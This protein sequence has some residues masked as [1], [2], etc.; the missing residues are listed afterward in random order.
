[1]QLKFFK[2]KKIKLPVKE[3]PTIQQI[4]SQATSFRAFCDNSEV[5]DINRHKVI[6]KRKTLFQI[7]A[8]G[9][10]VD[11]PVFIISKN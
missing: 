5:F 11:S 9:I 10:D 4:F 1:M 8:H 7:Y 6:K 2:R 3:I